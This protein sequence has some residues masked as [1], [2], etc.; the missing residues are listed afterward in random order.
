MSLTFADLLNEVGNATNSDESSKYTT[1][2]GIVNQALEYFNTMHAWDSL[3]GL[4]VDL[5]ATAGNQYIDLPADCRDI[6]QID[7]SG[8]GLGRFEFTDI[9]TINRYWSSNAV[10]S[11]AGHYW[12]ARVTRTGTTGPIEAL[13][14]HPEIGAT[15]ADTFQICYRRRLTPLNDGV[16]AD[17]EYIQVA[18]F[19]EGLV[20]ELV[21]TFALG[22]EESGKGEVSERL[23]VLENSTMVQRLKETDGAMAPEMGKML[24]GDGM[25]RYDIFA[26]SELELPL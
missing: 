15:M 20:R 7:V 13:A 16:A 4:P 5:V 24:G 11:T 14:V 6:I 17:S 9:A 21:R 8:S 12:G 1:Q 23:E 10:G 26:D 19:L 22:I 18:P 2:T 3:V 25:G